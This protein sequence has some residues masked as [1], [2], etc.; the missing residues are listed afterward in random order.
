MKIIDSLGVERFASLLFVSPLQINFITPAGMAPGTAL[1]III[2]GIV[3]TSAG[4]VQIADVV[5]GIFTANSS[6]TGLP[7]AQFLRVRADGT[8]SYEPVARFDPGLNQFVAVPVDLGS[9]PGAA[10]DEVFLVLFGTGT[11]HRHSQ[12][13]ISARIGGDEAEVLYAG[14]QGALLGL[15]QIN[16]RIPRSL[17]GR[18]DVN[19]V[20]TV[21]GKI[22]NTVKI[23]VR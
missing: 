2:S 1:V 18:G 3:E 7:A 13:I 23:N 6:G 12:G 17:I 16:L 5:P 8:S 9:S 14:A 4:G 10:T 11:R 21:D 15:D 20:L 22:A 19:V